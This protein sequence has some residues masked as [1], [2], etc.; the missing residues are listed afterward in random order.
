[1]RNRSGKNLLPGKNDKTQLGT[2]DNA[3]RGIPT[4]VENDNF[5]WDHVQA[6]GDFT[7]ATAQG[8]LY[9]WG[10]NSYG[11]LGNDTQTASAIP[12]SV[13]TGHTWDH[14]DGGGL[15]TCAIAQGKI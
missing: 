3:T 2:G 9:C 4:L 13:G 10:S 12:V 6:G 15:H 5:H 14:V 1:M 7:C 11:E 8:K